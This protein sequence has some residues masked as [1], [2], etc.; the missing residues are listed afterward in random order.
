[1]RAVPQRRSGLRVTLPQ[2]LLMVGIATGIWFLSSFSRLM[3]RG[4]TIRAQ[5]S[6]L[7]ATV[8][9]LHQAQVDLKLT[10]AYV[11]S[12]AFVER[13]LRTNLQYGRP[14]ETHLV[15]ITPALDTSTNNTLAYSEMPQA[16]TP[17][18]MLWRNLFFAPND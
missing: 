2:V 12:D 3:E 8:T 9:A 14:G 1:M 5:E 13:A 16:Q 6:Q 17:N 7:V 10:Q 18:W 11:S 4:H 15:V